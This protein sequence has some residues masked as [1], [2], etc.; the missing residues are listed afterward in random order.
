VGTLEATK[1]GRTD[2]VR[3]AAGTQVA[4]IDKKWTGVLKEMLTTVD[5]YRVE[6]HH[7]LYDPLRVLVAVS[8]VALDMIFF[9]QK[10]WP[11]PG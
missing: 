1:V 6:I 9:E 5:R 10:D 11:V 4:Q 7:P 2:R 8:A 3:D